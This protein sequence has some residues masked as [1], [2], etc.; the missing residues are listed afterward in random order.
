MEW[1]PR[2]MA[3]LA[4]LFE[5]LEGLASAVGQ[6]VIP[7]RL[8]VAGNAAA[9]ASGLLG[10]ERL[11]WLG[12]ALSFF[13]VLFHIAWA[14]LFYELF[15]PVSRAVSRLAAFVILVGC[16]MQAVTGLLY[17]V[18]LLVLRGAVPPAAFTPDQQ[19]GIAYLFLRLNGSAFNMYLVFFGLWCALIGYL[20]LKST[21]LPR[22]L[23]ALMM[24]NGLGWMSFLVPPL[25]TRL[26]PFVAG[27]SALAELPLMLWLLVKGVDEERW[28][29][30][31]G[32]AAR[33]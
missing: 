25:G 8:I 17:I 6:V 15:E 26:F 14:L 31:A 18:P 19:E 3:R 2:R 10:H 23:G 32:V 29:E 7:G 22:V 9:T 4:G 24:L 33:N 12:F 11:Y 1:S 13:G 16:A 21:F 30:Q 27:A 28:R 20:I 5:A